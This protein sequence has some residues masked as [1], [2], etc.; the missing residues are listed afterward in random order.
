MPKPNEE[1]A[2][3]AER[4]FLLLSEGEQRQVWNLIEYLYVQG[5][6]KTMARDKAAAAMIGVGFVFALGAAGTSDTGGDNFML[7]L[8]IGAVLMLIG[9]MIGMTK[10]SRRGIP[11]TKQGF[12]NPTKF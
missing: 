5:G 11:H 8:I 1:L 6:D 10:K 9:G 2:K 12:Q 4:I 7:P 3:E